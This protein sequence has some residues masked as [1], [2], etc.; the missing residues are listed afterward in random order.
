MLA[1]GPLRRGTPRREISWTI[2]GDMCDYL[3]QIVFVF[4]QA[5][6]VRRLAE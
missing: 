5:V 2:D 1:S 3:E 4:R 6:Y